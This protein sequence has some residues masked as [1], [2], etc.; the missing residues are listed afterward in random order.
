M[1]VDTMKA[2]RPPGNEPKITLEQYRRILELKKKKEG[3]I[4]DMTYVELAKELGLRPSA[5]INAA[6]RR[7][8]RY[9]YVLWKEGEI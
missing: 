5:V 4:R 3:P 1:K 2:P 6:R 9:D 7:I 8:K